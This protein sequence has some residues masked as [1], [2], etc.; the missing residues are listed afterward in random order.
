MRGTPLAVQQ[1][2]LHT[3]SGVD[4][5]PMYDRPV[6]RPPPSFF[7]LLLVP[8]KPKVNIAWVNGVATVRTFARK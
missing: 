5:Q 8:Y 7:S 2:H 6:P 1:K 3:W 4:N